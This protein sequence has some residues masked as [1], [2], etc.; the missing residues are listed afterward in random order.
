MPVNP[1]APDAAGGIAPGSSPIG[2]A[3]PPAAVPTT[4][5][6]GIQP[7]RLWQSSF[8]DYTAANYSL[9]IQG[10]E[11]YLKYFPKGQQAHEAQL[12]VGEALYLDKKDADAVVAYERVIANYPGS[13]SVPTAYYKR[14]LALERLGEAARAKESYDAVIKQFPE[15][16]AASMARQRLETVSKPAK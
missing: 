9:A 16:N 11:S 15:T 14:G 3:Q 5:P 4:P 12:Y 2:L 10:F 6:S 8:A 13:A 1:G 7:Q